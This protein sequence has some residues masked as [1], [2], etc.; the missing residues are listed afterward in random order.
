MC[1][2]VFL[3]IYTGRSAS[4]LVG[5]WAKRRNLRRSVEDVLPGHGSCLPQTVAPVSATRVRVLL[6]CGA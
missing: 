2:L 5:G 3:C 4:R 1:I 6:I